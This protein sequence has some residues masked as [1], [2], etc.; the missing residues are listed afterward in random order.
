MLMGTAQ[1][2][3]DSTTARALAADESQRAVD[4]MSIDIRQAQE[5]Q[6]QYGAVQVAGANELKLFVNSIG[7]GRPQLV[8]YYVSGSELWRSVY[9]VSNTT[10]PDL[11]ATGWTFS[12]TPSTNTRLVQNLVTTNGNLFC[13]HDRVSDAATV[14]DAPN[15]Q[16]HGFD[17]VPATVIATPLGI[18]PDT[19]I[20]MIGI[21]LTTT[22]TSGPKTAT[23]NSNVLVRVR[24]LANDTN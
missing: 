15:N 10:T 19:E 13:Y 8:R 11:T 3:T 12:S 7:N 17:L 18:N 16:N 1:A 5:N 23:I 14:C 2:M 22:Q 21:N 4:R 20:S 24:S 6:L 9:L